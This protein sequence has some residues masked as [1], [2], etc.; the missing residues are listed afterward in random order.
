[1]LFC[2]L[3]NKE[4]STKRNCSVKQHIETLKHMRLKE[5][6]ESIPEKGFIGPTTQ[7]FARALCKGLILADI[8]LDKLNNPDFKHFLETFTKFEV[9]TFGVTYQK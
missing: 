1:M 4:V 2:T 6:A 3:Y 7:D 8:P 5:Q 9:C